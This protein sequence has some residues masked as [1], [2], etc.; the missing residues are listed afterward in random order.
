M[1]DVDRATP[2]PDALLGGTEADA[3]Q[4]DEALPPMP[5][6]ECALI[7]ACA[8]RLMCHTALPRPGLC[9]LQ[10]SSSLPATASTR[11]WSTWW[12]T[13]STRWRRRTP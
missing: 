12:R 8:E 11:P 7:K 9:S 13:S 4:L 2:P 3:E 6:G 1:E 5:E 10:I